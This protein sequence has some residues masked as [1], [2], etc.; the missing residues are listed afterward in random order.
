MQQVRL[1][2][3]LLLLP[4]IFSAAQNRQITH[5]FKQTDTCMALQA[6]VKTSP[7]AITESGFL[8][9][10]DD[11]KCIKEEVISL[12]PLDNQTR[13]SFTWLS[14]PRLTNNNATPVNYVLGGDNIVPNTYPYN[15]NNNSYLQNLPLNSQ[16]NTDFITSIY[17]G[18]W[19]S[20]TG[21]DNCQSTLGYKLSL[22][23][24][25]NPN[26]AVKLYLHGNALSPSDSINT[27]YGNDKEN[28]I[29]Y[30]L[31]Q[32][33]SPFDAIADDVLDELTEIKAQN[34]F[35]Y[36]DWS[37][38]Q[39]NPQWI[40]GVGKGVNAP[41]LNY[42]D[43]VIL[44]SSN[45]ISNFQ[46][47]WGNKQTLSE[48]KSATEHYQYDE[49]ADYTAYLIEI[50]TANRPDEIGA[51]IGNTCIG[52]SKVLSSDT[53]VLIRGYDTD[54][55]GMVYFVEYFN[56]QKSSKPALKEYYVKNHYQP[57]WQ[58]RSINAAEK[59][60]HYLISFKRKK[61]VSPVNNDNDFVLKVY[62]NPAQNSLTV[63]YTTSGE[64]N[65]TLEIYDITGKKIINL[66]TRMTAGMHQN[67]INTQTLKNG[68]YLLRLSIRNKT[69]VK[70]FVIN[71]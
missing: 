7:V 45:D 71:K 20:N 19:T 70:R 38:G 17:N 69:A 66:Q 11:Y 28:W 27:L 14:F 10:M 56:S 12:N 5:I 40:C 37:M 60:G 67:V 15:Y 52:A 36:K 32:E 68:I 43:M 34:W 53:L 39:Q 41:N 55:T 61:T 46:W 16:S 44:K 64:V 18:Y 33:Q 65:T 54:T 48:I 57:G 4:P 62:P 22:M 3:F 21:L 59:E 2:L 42:G 23:Y 58:K 25:A 29:G 31:Y 30:W 26:Q 24:N 51:F 8:Y 35:C 49:E 1:F 50:D 9:L 13:K 6:M 63:E 47:Q